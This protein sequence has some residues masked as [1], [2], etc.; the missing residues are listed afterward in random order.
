MFALMDLSLKHLITLNP[1]LTL[2]STHRELQ[3]D[4]EVHVDVSIWAYATEAQ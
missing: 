4:I 3:A 1:V 2:Y